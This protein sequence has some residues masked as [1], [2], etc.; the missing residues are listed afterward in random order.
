[1]CPESMKPV[2][3]ALLALGLLPLS[4]SLSLQMNA[5]QAARE[6]HALAPAG[7]HSN[8]GAD[9]V[10]QPNLGDFAWLVGRWQGSWGPRTT[11]QAWLPPKGD[12]MVGTFQVNEDGRTL[13][14]ELYSLIQTTGSIELHLRHFTPSLIPWEKSAG[15]VL[16]LTS[17]DSRS[18]TFENT[19]DGQPERQSLTRVDSDTYIFRAEIASPGA[20]PQVVSISYRRQRD[21]VAAHRR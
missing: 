1:M 19:S 3:I 18:L 6:N 13:V 11:Q 14:I 7:M 12:T 15:T 4:V 2:K 20:H 16:R 17:F 5:P 8:S 10:G 9:P 21:L